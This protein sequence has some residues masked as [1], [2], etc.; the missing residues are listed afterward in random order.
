MSPNIG[1]LI[2]Q[3]RLPGGVCIFLGEEIV[4]EGRS[5]D[6]CSEELYFE[7]FHPVEGLVFE[8]AYYYESIHFA[9][10]SAEKYI[11]DR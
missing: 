7:V 8:P 10:E 5:H 2:W 1:D 6:D 4:E 11:E 9:L 3:C